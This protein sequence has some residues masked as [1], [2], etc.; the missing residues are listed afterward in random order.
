MQRFLAS[1]R[2]ALVG[3]ST[4][5]RH[6]SRMVFDAWSKAGYDMVPVHPTA[7]T[8]AG[9]PAFALVEDV[10]PPPDAVLIMTPPRASAA[11]IEGAIRAGVQRVWLSGGSGEG[12]VSEAAVAIA[13]AAQLDLVTGEC[14]M[15]ALPGV[16]FIHRAHRFFR[17]HAWRTDAATPA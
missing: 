6:F 4:R 7:A 11:A 17:Q 8:I 16:G 5:P 9:R 10:V 15:I 13:R 12:S 3:A 14:P 2:V 1:R